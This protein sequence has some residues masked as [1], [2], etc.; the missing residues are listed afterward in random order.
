MNEFNEN[1]NYY[2]PQPPTFNP[3]E[4]ISNPAPAPVSPLGR[5]ML[6][7][8]EAVKTCLIDKYCCFK[9]RARRSE[10]WWFIL[11]LQIAGFIV[12]WISFG[13]YFK[14]HTMMDYLNDPMT[15]LKSPAMIVLGVYSLALLLPQLGAIVRR[16]HDTGRTGKW[17]FIYLASIIPIVGTVIVLIFFIILIV[18]CAQDSERGENKYGPSP[19]YQ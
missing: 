7:F 1:Q 10:F 5:P 3:A 19:K 13:I 14:D 9:G 15:L 12:S 4:P 2:G 6:G 11:A 17:L 16:L 18:W 8:M